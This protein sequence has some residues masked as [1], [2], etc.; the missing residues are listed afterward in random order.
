VTWDPQTA[1][2]RFELRRRLGEGSFGVVYE[3]WDRERESRVALKAL[4]KADAYALYNL[5]REFRSLAN[6]S[7]RNVVDLYELLSDGDQWFITMELVEGENFFYYVRGELQR[8]G[9]ISDAIDSTEETVAYSQ[10]IPLAQVDAE[11]TEV[12][13]P[14]SEDSQE[15]ATHPEL[16]RTQGLA[17]SAEAIERLRHALRS[18]A[19]GLVAL[20]SAGIVHRDLKPSNV[21]VS[22]AGRVTILDFGLV[23]E[24]E[25]HD[26]VASQHIAGTPAYM[27]PE[28]AMGQPLTEACDWFAVGVMLW[29]A[30]VGYRPERGGD[31]L[32]PIPPPG[33]L[34]PGVPED[35]DRLCQDLVRRHPAE[36]PRGKEVL[37]RL[38]VTRTDAPSAIVRDAQSPRTSFVGR[39]A[40]L[41]DLARAFEHTERGDVAV[42]LVHGSSGM[43]KTSLVRQFLADLERRRRDAV[44]LRGR[45]IESESVPYKAVDSLV[46]SLAVYMAG[47]PKARVEGLLPKD[48]L[49]LARLF[50]VLRRVSAVADARRRFVEISDSREL[51]RRA[52]AALRDLLSRLS[53]RE[54]TILF[55]DDL[56]WGDED[57]AALLLDVLRP[58]DVPPLLLIVTYRTEE[59]ETSPSLQSF[60]EVERHTDGRDIFEI[61]VAEFSASEGRELARE[62][63]SDGAE[64]AVASADQLVAE[65]A[66]NP[67]LLEKLAALARGDSG[68]GS[69]PGK[70]LGSGLDELLTDM[71]SDLD[72]PAQQLLEV[73]AVMG[74]PTR[75]DVATEAASLETSIW[76]M[77]KR[78]ETARLVRLRETRRGEEIELYHD[79]IRQ[80]VIRSLSPE[81]LVEHHRRLFAA[82]SAAGTAD[83]EA[84]AVH[85]EGAGDL[86]SAAHYYAAAGGEAARALAFA[87]ASRH[88]RRALELGELEDGET[89]RLQRA[90]GDALVNAGRGTEAAH[91]FLLAAQGSDSAE[92]LELRRRAAQHFLMSG[93]LDEGMKTIESVLA[94]Q[95]LS[96]PGTPRR[97]LLSILLNR[98]R[99][100]LRGLSYRERA[101]S[102]IPEA[103]LRLIDTCWAVTSGLILSNTIYALDFQGRGLWRALR[104]GEPMRVARALSL[105]Q[106]QSANA[107]S[108]GEKRTLR[109]A[110]AAAAAAKRAHTPL[111]TGLSL[112]YTGTARALNG[113]WRSAVDLADRAQAVFR[114]RCT[115]VAY[116]LDTSHL[117]VL[118]GLSWLAEF[119]L[120]AKRLTPVQRDAEERGDLFMV[121]YLKTDIAPRV[122]LAEDRPEHAREAALDGIG[123]WPF[124]GYHRQHQYALRAQVEV[125]LYRGDGTAA[126]KLIDLEYEAL[127]GSLLLRTQ[128]N[129]II[130]GDY[131][132]RG[133]LAASFEAA[134]RREAEA[135]RAV[136]TAEVRNIK[137]EKTRWG[138]PIANQLEAA[139]A[140]AIGDADR[141]RELLAQAEAGF[142]AAAMRLHAAVARIRRGELL[143]GETGAKLVSGAEEWMRSEGL[144]RPHRWVRML[145]PQ[146]G[147]AEPDAPDDET[148]PAPS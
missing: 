29:E 61:E 57:S 98:L 89:R 49:A 25:T 104:A 67:F 116:E 85:A 128:M 37:E 127:R 91:A 56:H 20:H 10:T 39:V 43:G 1:G 130:V 66:G 68:F 41:R 106:L 55:I 105:E 110:Q 82:L 79:R 146:P 47:L 133:A 101:A 31:S 17:A 65:A 3:A 70:P 52:F 126:W 26:V 45:C 120:L 48:V 147:A 121:T 111:A 53:E 28:Q 125:E 93:R 81:T 118:F 117:V 18:L 113:E 124:P 50:P 109:V 86:A 35:L 95:G 141:A 38:G 84:L 140:L 64:G 107:G 40:Q 136:A 23:R 16:K 135:L 76:P 134:D 9:D 137:R 97:A 92:S 129:R 123:R 72:R 62:L 34:V 132:G 138:E 131:R 94:A 32:R 69:R 148:G 119:R 145:S 12:A 13:R 36:R 100:R 96:M 30:L 58:P 2:G 15:L 54:P 102:D 78:I 59:V 6:I 73:L 115:G 114:E 8:D 75:L 11:A 22:A 122:L 103:E 4:K 142:D 143:G 63:L 33:V 24:R 83:A 99:L 44:V 60:L 144:R 19:E 71:V 87:A 46:D 42:A 21:L 5:K 112:L 80:A 7:H 77:L 74:R 139:I 108:Q 90:M 14:P 51:R 27:A 88:Y